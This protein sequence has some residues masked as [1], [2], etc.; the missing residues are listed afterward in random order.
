MKRAFIWG[1]GLALLVLTLFAADVMLDEFG[2]V[3][4]KYKRLGKVRTLEEAEA[5]LGKRADDREEE[6][7]GT[8][9]VWHWEPGGIKIL[10]DERGVARKTVL[11][12]TRLPGL[13]PHLRKALGE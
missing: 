9:L 12:E 7:E 8:W 3:E 1:L 6:Q 5:I 10:F 4:A 13:L 2:T 11:F